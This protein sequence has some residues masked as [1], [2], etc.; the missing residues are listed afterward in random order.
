MGANE[1]RHTFRE[2]TKQLLNAITVIYSNI[3]KRPTLKRIIAAESQVFS[4]D[5]SLR[6]TFRNAWQRLPKFCKFSELPCM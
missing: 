1:K 6:T 4:D 3:H 2:T 5:Y